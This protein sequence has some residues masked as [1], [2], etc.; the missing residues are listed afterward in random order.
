[1]QIVSAYRELGIKDLC[2]HRTRGVQ[3][4]VPAEVGGP[5]GP[6]PESAAADPPACASGLGCRGAGGECADPS[7]A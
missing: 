6:P 2:L 5:D 4:A 3:A 7:S 1:M